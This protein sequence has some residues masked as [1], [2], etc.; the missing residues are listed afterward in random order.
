MI[1][2]RYNKTEKLLGLLTLIAILGFIA[3]FAIINFKGF[4]NFCDPDMYED[5]LIARLMW[6]QKTLFPYGYVFGNQLYVIATPVLAALF[7][8]LTGSQ[9][10]SMALA[11][12]V[13]TVL[14]LLS[15]RWMLKPFVK[16][17]LS[18][19][20]AT[21]MLMACAF[22]NR[23]IEQDLGQLLFVMCSYYA[24]Y[25][26]T[27]F[28]VMGDYARAI[29]GTATRPAVFVLSLFLCFATGMQSM[30]QTCMMVL[31]IL[32]FQCLLIV[33]DWVKNRRFVW[34]N[35]K[36]P[37]LRAIAYMLAN[38][39]GILVIKLMDVHQN[40]IYESSGADLGQK[41]SAIYG[42]L[43]GI[44]GFKWA[45]SD[46][47]FFTVMAVSEA[48]LLA[49]ALAFQIK[50]IKAGGGISAL[51]WLLL[52]SI[53]AAVSASLVTPLSIR[54]VY[55]FTYYPLV[56]VSALLVM[57]SSPQRARYALA[58]AFC[59][60]AVGNIK[61]SYFTSVQDSL[62][63]VDNPYS[64]ISD[65]AVE[66]GYELVY[67]DYS[68]AAPKIAVN[69]NGKLISGGWNR[70]IMFKAQE[71]LNLQNIYSEEDV[72]RAIFVFQEHELDYAFEA[73]EAG[74]GELIFQGRY[75]D[76]YV[77]TSTVQLMYPRTYPWFDIQWNGQWSG[78]WNYSYS[79]N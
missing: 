68:N 36:I 28:V 61:H 38:L 25:V 48:I 8:G 71:Y 55:L 22:G 53:A 73:A 42:A 64:Q 57:E 5:T 26:V 41:I 44:S 52:I 43:L 74:G 23:L 67:A 33:I 3:V 77:Y 9:N 31:P 14:I 27:M 65:W 17:R 75:G 76:F 32:A 46:Y 40:T 60:F 6:E 63:E 29:E 78:Q 18:L 59:I 2:N 37:S 79:R 20:S 4:V 66:N 70:E 13:M 50:R 72:E 11:T 51:W 19:L 34:E 49:C 16:N 39:A 12:S 58:L 47:P 69:S 10:T 15:F 24:C 30:R 54:G 62:K 56:A 7:Y 45:Y 1:L 35:V 21:L